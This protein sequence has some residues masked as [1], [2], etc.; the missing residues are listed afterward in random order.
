MLKQMYN[1]LEDQLANIEFIIDK[2]IKDCEQVDD[3]KPLQYFYDLK[4]IV[5]RLRNE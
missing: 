1:E 2:G 4:K 5:E 3:K